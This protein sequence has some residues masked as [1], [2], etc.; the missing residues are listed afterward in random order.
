MSIQNFVSLRKFRR[1]WRKQNQEN[2]T[3]ALNKFNI[4]QVSVGKCTYGNVYAL[5][6]DN[7]S[8]LLIGNF[9]SIGPN[10]SFIVSADHYSNHISTFPYKVKICGEQFEGV[11]KGDIIVDDDVWIGYGAAILS[12]VHIGQGAVIAAGAVVSHDVPPYAIVGGVPAHL[13]KYRFSPDIINILLTI[14]YS[15]LEVKDIKEHI[16]DLYSEIKTVE[17]AKKLTSWMPKKDNA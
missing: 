6:F 3:V 7:T 14:D 10:V 5:T 12:G 8:K 4:G 2:A 11:S 15:K 1:L 9:C 13:I 16:N 17:D